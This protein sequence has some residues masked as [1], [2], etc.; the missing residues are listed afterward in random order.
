MFGTIL[1]GIPV[2]WIIL[3]S[4]LGGKSKSINAPML[5]YEVTQSG[6][7]MFVKYLMAG[8][9]LV[10]ALS[11]MIQF[12]SYFL[13]NAAILLREPGAKLYQPEQEASGAS[14]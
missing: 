9:L 4:G 1:L 6:Y 7:G 5:A 14:S 12:I 2:C 11:M 3:T 10:Y 8:F 13:Q